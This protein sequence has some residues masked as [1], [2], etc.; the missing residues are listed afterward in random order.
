MKLKKK[1]VAGL[2]IALLI[3]SCWTLARAEQESGSF[4]SR[5]AFTRIKNLAGEW[6]GRVMDRE[7]GPEVTVLYRVTAGGS[8]VLETLFPGTPHEMLT[9]YHLDGDKL[10]LTHYCAMGNQPQMVLD[11][12]STVRQLVFAFVGGSNLNPGRDL[13]MHAGRISFMTGD[14]LENEWDTF[15]D[16]KRVETKTFYLE[17]KK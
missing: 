7:K 9:V 10:M 4:T 6:R 15:Q 17:R 2:A 13:H 8:A 14:R 11:P 16:G 3:M 1:S 5:E 12:G